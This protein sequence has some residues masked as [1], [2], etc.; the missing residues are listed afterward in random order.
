MEQT[1]GNDCAEVRAYPC[2]CFEYV[3]V[4]DREQAPFVPAPGHAIR[5]WC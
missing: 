5:G 1:V 2:Q 3:T 4:F